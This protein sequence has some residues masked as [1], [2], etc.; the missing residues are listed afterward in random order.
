MESC[1]LTLFYIVYV[2]AILVVSFLLCDI[3]YIHIVF[4]WTSAEFLSH[5]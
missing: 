4:L 2:I 1:S 3:L 5:I